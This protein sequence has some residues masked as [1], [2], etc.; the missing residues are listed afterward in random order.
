MLTRT[1][2]FSPASGF[3]LLL[4]L[5]LVA[6]PSRGDGKKDGNLEIPAAL[7]EDAR[8]ALETG[9]AAFRIAEKAEKDRDK[10]ASDAVAKLK[11]AQ[12]K[13]SEAA[14]SHFYLARAHELRRNFAEARKCYEK[15]LKLNPRF[16]EALSELA[17]IHYNYRDKKKA[18]E[19]FDT[20][21]E[22]EPTYLQALMGKGVVQC[23]MGDISGARA[24][25][26]AAQKVLPQPYITELIKDLD[27]DIQGP[28][29]TTA[30]TRETENYIVLTQTSQ[31]FADE[32][33]A[34]A[35]L[36]RRAYNKV[37]SNIQKPD[38]KYKILV[39]ANREA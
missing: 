21:I 29:W 30:Y 28:D 27:K 32:I 7:P 39:N 12:A 9:V 22:I 18:L 16:H 13:A 2:S 33:G 4:L 15:A 10:A 5:F 25:F 23:A 1:G 6:P 24:T 19:L 38:R 3:S 35:E 8:K 14:V 31:E 20:A 34:H 36:I 37:F 26:A 17:G 11:A